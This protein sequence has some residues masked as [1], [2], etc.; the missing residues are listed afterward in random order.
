MLVAPLSLMLVKARL[1]TWRKAGI[2]GGAAVSAPLWMIEGPGHSVRE[3]D[4]RSP[5]ARRVAYGEGGEP[6][7][8]VPIARGTV[9]T[10]S[11]ALPATGIRVVTDGRC[12][13]D[14]PRLSA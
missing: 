5:S 13:R 4:D 8:I 14:V 2:D 3:R 10:L 7:G 9:L 1:T 12:A 11:S 6:A